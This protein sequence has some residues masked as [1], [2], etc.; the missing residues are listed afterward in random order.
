MLEDG[1]L[2]RLTEKDIRLKLAVLFRRPVGAK[3]PDSWRG[4]PAPP[5]SW[6]AGRGGELRL[7]S[8]ARRRIRDMQNQQAQPSSQRQAEK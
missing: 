3:A 1:R 8:G 7:P 5:F 6:G 4:G 2:L